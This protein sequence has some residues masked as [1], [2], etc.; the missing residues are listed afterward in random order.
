VTLL[1]HNI[2]R[3][4]HGKHVCRECRQRIGAREQYVDQRIAG[5]GTVY[6]YRAHERCFEIV[7]YQLG[8]DI[9][10]W[11]GDINDLCDGHDMACVSL[12]SKQ[13][14]NCGAQEAQQ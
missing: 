13:A 5:Y 3:A 11:N 14:C 6:T 2:R 4:A 10:D 1:S 8:Y 12:T 7:C 9:E